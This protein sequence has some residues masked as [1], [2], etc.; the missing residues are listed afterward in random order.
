MSMTFW[1]QYDACT[2]AAATNISL[3]QTLYAFGAMKSF[4][5][6]NF[7]CGFFIGIFFVIVLFNISKS[8][9]DNYIPI[10]L[11]DKE[12]A[13]LELYD[14]SLADFLYNEVKILCYVFT[15]ADNHKTKVRHVMNTWGKRCNKLL[16]ISNK[17]DPDLPGIVVLPVE[18]GRS[19]LWFKA[20]HALK[21][22]HDHHLN[23]AD[24]FLRADDDNYF[25]IEN[26]RHYLYQ[27]RTKTSIHIGHRY[28]VNYSNTQDGY[29]A[30]GGQIFS[31]KAVIKFATKLYPNPLLCDA[32]DGE[33][34]D[35]L[36]GRCLWKFAY[37]ID[38]R[39]EKGEKLLFPGRHLRNVMLFLFT[40]DNLQ[41]ELRSTSRTTLIQI[42]GGYEL[43]EIAE[44][45]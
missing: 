29:M 31:K 4:Q 17:E 2:R 42:T 13:P 28:A 3:V 34:E 22:I 14:H 40:C 36:I 15:H 11:E 25:V 6:L 27:Y 35:M 33:A 9:K 5:N 19:H 41:L 16:I 44:N 39:D 8:N 7:A 37:F 1:M 38:A 24:W 23:D 18:N 30:G 21:Y 20:R 32:N 12:V 10:K 26:I 43:K 45:L